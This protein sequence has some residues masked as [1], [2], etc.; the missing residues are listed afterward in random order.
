VN[1]NAI[2]VHEAPEAVL[3]PS[4]ECADEFA[5]QEATKC[6]CRGGSEPSHQLH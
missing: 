3:T 5:K 2:V 6:M 1:R 4:P